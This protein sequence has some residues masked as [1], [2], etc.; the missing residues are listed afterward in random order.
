[1]NEQELRRNHRTSIVICSILA[2]VIIGIGMS[3]LAVMHDARRAMVT[4]LMQTEAREVKGRIMRQIRKDNEAL[5]ALSVFM[6]GYYLS[7]KDGFCKRFND[8]KVS[9]SFTG[10]AYFGLDGIG[11]I[12]NDND[13]IITDVNYR[14]LGKDVQRIIEAGYEGR[15]SIASVSE[16]DASERRVLYY[17]VPVYGG[18]EVIGVLSATN[19]LEIFEEMTDGDKILDGK[20]DIHLVDKNGD[21][22]ISSYDPENTKNLTTVLYSNYFFDYNTQQE[23]QAALAEDRELFCSMKYGGRSYRVYLY[24]LGFNDWYLMCLHNQEV[25]SVMSF[26]R[27]KLVCLIF[28]SLFLAVIV[29]F[30]YMMRVNYKNIRNL[31]KIAYEDPL[32]S[33]DN[34]T[35]FMKNIT[36]AQNTEDEF[37]LVALNVY[38][39]K[40]IN[41]MLGV[42]VAD[43]IL[44]Y[45]CACLN[46]TLQEGEFFCRES[47]DLFFIC[48]RDTD[49]DTV[50]WRLEHI[51]R[52]ISIRAVPEL[53]DFTVSTYAGVLIWTKEDSGKL[54]NELLITRTRFAMKHISRFSDSHIRFYDSDIHRREEMENYVET[55]MHKALENGEFKLFLQPKINLKTG[56]LGGAEALVRWITP[57]GQMIFPD[58]FIPLFERNGFCKQL[59][60]Y[61]FEQACKQI[62]EWTDKG[63]EP[64]PIS[65]NQSKLVFFNGNYVSDL[66]EMVRKYGVKPSMITLEILE[67]LVLSNAEELNRKLRRL[68]DIGF[69][70]S[71]DD[72][73]SGYS[74]FNSLGNLEI[75]ELKIDRAFLMEVSDKKGDRFK[76]ILTHIIEL[77]KNLNISTVA[78]GVE[79]SENEDLI[80][81][82]GCDYGQGYLY[83]RP[84]SRDEFGERFMYTNE[85]GSIEQPE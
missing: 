7:D 74:S 71:M 4:E 58:V 80:N 51:M 41:E 63:V 55:R 54:S 11:V 38:Q 59:D 44:R 85:N 78:E 36:R 1:M 23:I 48:M 21:L 13:G 9:S 22:L 82:L 64:I 52:E 32:T 46:K 69:R 27:M 47:N 57:E 18:E 67:G 75:D 53:K 12:V 61:M 28:G 49:R 83:S 19:R 81:G 50:Q 10:M 72:F 17:A 20:G 60:M 56:K 40:F 24:P 79:T 45:I 33:A 39:F 34:M 15:S 25:L 70:I 14:S 8:A 37:T 16:G 6:D 68:R 3:A 42:E 76:T 66:E 30:T 84:I 35:R 77:S 43:E 26:N 2:A 29:M 5:E 73:G 62:K 31:I 65:V